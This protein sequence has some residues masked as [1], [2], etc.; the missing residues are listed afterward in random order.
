M[1]ADVG[2]NQIEEIDVVERGGNYGWRRME[3]R[4]CYHPASGCERP[5]LGLPIAEYQHQRGRC[6]ITGGYVYRGAAMPRLVG[7]YLFGDYCSG[8]IFGLRQGEIV[9]LLESGLRIASFGEDASGEVYVVD[10]GGAI[11]R[12]VGGAS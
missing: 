6:S 8:E 5:G 11:Y 7:T 4:S 1:V 3:G 10:H 9:L 12:I 2:Q